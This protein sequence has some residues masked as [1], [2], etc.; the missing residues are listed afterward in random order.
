MF[1]VP[2][3]PSSILL[4]PTL[5]Y[6]HHPIATAGSGGSRVA[7]SKKKK[8]KAPP[9]SRAE[10][11]VEG[12]NWRLALTQAVSTQ[13]LSVFLPSLAQLPLVTSRH[14]HRIHGALFSAAGSDNGDLKISTEKKIKRGKKGRKKNTNRNCGNTCCKE[15]GCVCV[16][17]L[18]A[19]ERRFK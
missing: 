6:H 12:K 13:P 17:G 1:S 9:S 4:E 2:L 14:T 7:A 10:V 16:F 15:A 11:K 19:D 18:F 5:T 3:P 8:K